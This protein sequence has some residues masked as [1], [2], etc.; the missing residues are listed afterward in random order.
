M[1]TN[2][3]DIG[4]RSREMAVVK[5]IRPCL[6]KSHLVISITAHGNGIALE[7]ATVDRGNALV[8]LG[9]LLYRLLVGVRV[10]VHDIIRCIA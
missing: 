1:P 5:C 6:R 2:W 8:R 3:C 4:S 7:E 9:R 10:E